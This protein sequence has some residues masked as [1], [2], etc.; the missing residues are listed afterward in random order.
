M[1]SP[2]PFEIPFRHFVATQRPRLVRFVERRLGHRDDA[3]DLV[4][5]ALAEAA[6]A[7]QGFR[8]ASSLSTWIHGIALNLIR[9]H[10]SRSPSQRWDFEGEEALA[11]QPFDGPGPERSH[12]LLESLRRIDGEV[13][14]MS[15]A[16]REALLAVSVDELGFGAAALQ[17]GVT[18]A[19]VRHRVESA[20]AH[21][22]QRVEACF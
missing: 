14:R 12:E 17:L 13:A 3:E 4:Q 5:E 15:P 8:G 20:R 16:W 9:R 6:I 19:A 18:S 21:L 10:F 2:S 11:E 22:R 1:P 7:L